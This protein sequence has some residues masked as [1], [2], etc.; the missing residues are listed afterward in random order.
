MTGQDRPKQNRNFPSPGSQS[1]GEPVFLA[2]GKLRKPHGVRGEIEMEIL[3]DYPERL[4]KG[5]TLYI[6]NT[7]QPL[8]ILERRWK[9]KVLLLTFDG[10]NVREEVAALTNQLAFIK[11]SGLPA[12]PEGEYYHHELLG[13]QVIDESGQEIGQLNEIIETGANDVYL[14]RASSGQEILIP[15]LES[16]ILKVDLQNKQVTVRPQQWE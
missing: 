3:T 16:V 12:L 8:S 10:Y 9:D 7:H 6:G 14:V 15:A 1:S 5:T 4:S 11:S 13:L 2:V